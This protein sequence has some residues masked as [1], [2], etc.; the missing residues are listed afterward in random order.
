MT[1]GP[2]NTIERAMVRLRQGLL[3]GAPRITR[4]AQ[5]ALYGAAPGSISYIAADLR[6]L[7]LEDI[8]RGEN[9]NLAVGLAALLHDLDERVAKE[10]FASVD[11]GSVHPVIAAGFRSIQRFSRD[12]YR[13]SSFEHIEI[14]E[15]KS[16][17]VRQTKSATDYVT[18]WLTTVP[19]DDLAGI[20]RI[21]ISPE[22]EGAEYWGT[23]LPGLAVI[24]V[25]WE[26]AATRSWLGRFL[27]QKVLYHE[28]GHHVGRHEGGW[29]D[30]DDEKE[31]DAYAVR[32]MRRRYPWLR[33]TMNLVRRL[34]GK[35]RLDA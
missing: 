17:P 12:N 8:G 3:T 21:Y 2:E 11:G 19:A 13:R 30:P 4:E 14:F 20:S 27:I 6:R 24:N 16:L 1:L 15:H 26:T 9:G 34:K 22:S 29:Q 18:A 31:A 5:R 10:F 7:N 35:K 33:R 28:I 25:I 32:M 23:Y